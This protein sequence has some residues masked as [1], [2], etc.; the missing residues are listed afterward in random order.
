MARKRRTDP[1][2]LFSIVSGH[3]GP[4]GGPSKVEVQPL[5]VFIGRQGTGKSLVAQM[6]YLFR[7]LPSL[8]RFDA[9]SRRPDETED[10]PQRAVRRI[11][12]GMRSSHRSFA[13][14]TVP[15][16]R[17]RWQ[18]ALA[19][20]G[21][22]SHR[23]DLRLNVQNATSQVNATKALVEL[24][25]ELQASAHEPPLTAVFVPTERLLYAMALG[26]MSLQVMSA[27]LILQTFAQ[28]MELAGRIQG[29]WPG[30]V[31]DTT[32]GRWIRDRLIRALGGARCSHDA[33][34]DG[35]LHDQQPSDGV[36]A[37]ARGDGERDTA[38]DPARP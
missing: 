19:T 23:R 33:L 16:V 34:A 20:S 30:G 6:L 25:A 12:D 35:P 24:V 21:V 22:H 26:P 17:L 31:P 11:V 36:R 27:P 13:R 37:S 2:E 1:G 32:Q 4:L 3:L 29:D 14:L 10:T 28:M 7:G 18:G 15:N 9:A 38:R 5:T 8:V